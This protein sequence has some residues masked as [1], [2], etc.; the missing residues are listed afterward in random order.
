MD[1]SLPHSNGAAHVVWA[2]PMTPQQQEHT[3]VLT[4]AMR[5]H[6]AELASVA[7]SHGEA[8]W[9]PETP[10]EWRCAEALVRRGLLSRQA[11]RGEQ[12]FRITRAGLEAAEVT[13]VHTLFVDPA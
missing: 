10:G 8:G 6:L 4:A 13:Q 2:Q 5:R 1:I 9:H 12:P 11:K 3:V 7:N